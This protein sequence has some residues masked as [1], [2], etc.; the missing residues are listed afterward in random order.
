MTFFLLVPS[1]VVFGLVGFPAILVGAN[2]VLGRFSSMCDI[3]V[4]M[5]IGLFEHFSAQGTGNGHCVKA[6]QVTGE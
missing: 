1:K 5:H 2:L 6:L 3:E 4:L